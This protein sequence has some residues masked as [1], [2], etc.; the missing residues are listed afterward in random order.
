MVS[1]PEPATIVFP[2]V[3]P[4]IERAV[5]T[6]ER[7]SD[8]GQSRW[9]EEQ[10]GLAAMEAG[11]EAARERVEEALADNGRARE[12]V[13]RTKQHLAVRRRGAGDAP[14]LAK[15][16]VFVYAKPPVRRNGPLAFAR[17][18]PF[19]PLMRSGS[20]LREKTGRGNLRGA[21]SR[22][23]R[24]Q[25]SAQAAKARR[26]AHLAN[27]TAAR[28]RAVEAGAAGWWRRWRGSR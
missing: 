15:P 12:L 14:V 6:A 4:V 16:R 8:E 7:A 21:G 25:D 2:P 10:A 11:M 13:E 26:A 3:E 18:C 20:F 19:A 9:M 28:G 5:E 17:S 24:A 1:A 23:R 27:E 22:R